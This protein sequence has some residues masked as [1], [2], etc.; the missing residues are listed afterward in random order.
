MVTGGRS[1]GE[2]EI[3]NPTIALTIDPAIDLI[4][5]PI[6]DLTFDQTTNLAIDLVIVPALAHSHQQMALSTPILIA[7]RNLVLLLLTL[8]KPPTDQIRLVSEALRARMEQH[9]AAYEFV[10]EEGRRLQC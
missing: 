3:T 8:L 9:K 10:K 4:T 1:E 5:D 7:D 2:K 6:I